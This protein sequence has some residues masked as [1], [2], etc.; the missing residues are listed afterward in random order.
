MGCCPLFSRRTGVALASSEW[1]G[2]EV[3]GFGRS[4]AKFQLALVEVVV[5]LGVEG[6]DD[7]LQDDLGDWSEE[8]SQWMELISEVHAPVVGH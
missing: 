3:G 4:V 8:Q 2:Q 6:P 7:A 1:V 5:G